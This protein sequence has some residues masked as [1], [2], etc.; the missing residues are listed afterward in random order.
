MSALNTRRFVAPSLVQST[1]TDAEPRMCPAST[2]VARTPG[3]TSNG[4]SY[5]TPFMSSI[6]RTASR[7]AYSGS[8]CS[9]WWRERNSASCSWMCA[10]SASITSERSIVAGV[11]KIVLR[12]SFVNEKRQAARMIH[13][14]VREHD[15]R[16]CSEIGAGSAWFFAC[17]SSRC[18]WNSPQSSSTV[19]PLTCRM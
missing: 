7:V 4:S 5:A 14:R 2:K 8:A 6:V 12:V 13:V 19:R 9:L 15:R 17:T 18:P 16:R 1:I 10:E 11:A 3:T